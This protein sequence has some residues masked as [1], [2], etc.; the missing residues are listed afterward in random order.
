MEQLGPPPG[1]GGSP[2]ELIAWASPS[3][4]RLI[5]LHS[6]DDPNILG[7]ATDRGFRAAGT[8]LPQGPGYQELECALR[9]AG[10]VAW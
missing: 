4:S 1:H 3:G 8:P 9:T 5:L 7:V 10:Q 2:R 6:V